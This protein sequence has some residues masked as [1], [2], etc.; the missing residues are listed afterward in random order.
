MPYKI[1]GF[2]VA[3]FGVSFDASAFAT[4]LEKYGN[5]GF[6][7]SNQ[8]TR[9]VNT[10]RSANYTVTIETLAEYGNQKTTTQSVR[11]IPAGGTLVIGCGETRD[12]PITRFTYTIVGE[13]RQ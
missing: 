12:M 8:I 7:S 10:D 4:K 11:S 5:C 3:L 6:T 13:V 1:V 2:F 9:L